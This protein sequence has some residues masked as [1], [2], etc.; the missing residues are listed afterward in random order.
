[1]RE[2]VLSDAFSLLSLGDFIHLFNEYFL[3]CICMPG[4]LWGL[5][6]ECGTRQV[7]STLSWSLRFRGQRERIITE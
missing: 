1:M 7:R 2:V 6:I 4:P 3:S 5:G